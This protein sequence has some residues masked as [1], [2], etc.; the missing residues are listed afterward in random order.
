LWVTPS[1]VFY[2]YRRAPL[3]WKHRWRGHPSWELAVRRR[4]R[5]STARFT[6]RDANLRPYVSSITGHPE[7]L[8]RYRSRGTDPSRGL[9]LL[10]II[11]HVSTP[12][13][14]YDEGRTIWKNVDNRQKEVLSTRSLLDL[15]VW[16]HHPSSYESLWKRSAFRDTLN[17]N[18]E[19]YSLR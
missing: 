15:L 19:F 2:N 8:F 11:E 17:V 9:E 7:P 16:S 10:E 3:R 6:L 18:C 13:M 1:R 4:R 14:I 12:L 5:M